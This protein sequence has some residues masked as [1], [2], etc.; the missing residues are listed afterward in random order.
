MKK[1]S[2]TSKYDS[3]SDSEKKRIITQLYVDKQKSFADI[4]NQFDTYANKVRRD[5]KKFE[6]NIRDKSAAQK[7]A[8][9]TG[10]HKHPTKGLSRSDEVKA[11]IG[12]GVYKVWE[13]MDDSKIEEIK[14]SSLERW[15]NLSDDKKQH[16][17][18]LANQAV[19]VSS[20]TGSKLEKFILE[21]LLGDG[22]DVEFHKEQI[23]SN[24][25]LQIDLFLTKANIAIE[26]DGPSHFVPVWGEDSLKRNKGYD[27]KKSGLLIGKGIS[28][29]RIKQQKDFSKTR[30]IFIYD[31]LIVAINTIQKNK[32][33]FIEIGDT[34]G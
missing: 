32:D 20:K 2:N 10:K 12:L 9:Q 22:Y 18:H 34:D 5:A 33:T 27:A 24:T 28:L 7:N 13:S 21:K 8:L 17:I 31:K 23:L 11:K 1:S 4:A 6:I 16:I 30:A 19:R 14:K 15:N 25:K 29:I 26:I 3:L